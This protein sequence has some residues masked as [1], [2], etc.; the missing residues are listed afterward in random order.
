MSTFLYFELVAKKN[1]IEITKSNL[2]SYL[3][4]FFNF[5]FP[6]ILINIGECNSRFKRMHMIYMS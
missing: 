2:K 5:W 4:G 3:G 6:K 1:L